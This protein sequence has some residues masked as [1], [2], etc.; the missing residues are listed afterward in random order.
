MWFIVKILWTWN[1]FFTLLEISKPL[2]FFPFSAMSLSQLLKKKKLFPYFGNDIAA[3]AFILFYFKSTPH[4]GTLG[5]TRFKQQKWA[6]EFRQCHYRN[7]KIFSFLILSLAFWLNFGN[8]IVEIQSL[9]SISQLS[10]NNS[11]NTN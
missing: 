11:Y 4:S 5:H 7:S 8:A 1:L 6:V 10:L 2:F 3:I 9:S